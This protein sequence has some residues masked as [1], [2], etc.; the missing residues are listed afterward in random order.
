MKELLKCTCTVRWNIRQCI[1]K[2]YSCKQFL[3]L[4]NK[5]CSPEGSV[6]LMK[7]EAADYLQSDLD[8]EWFV[9]VLTFGPLDSNNKLESH[10]SNEVLFFEYVY[11]FI[12]IFIYICFAEAVKIFHL[13]I[14][15]LLFQFTFK[16]QAF[17]SKLLSRFRHFLPRYFQDQ[18]FSS[19]LLP[20]W[21]IFFQVTS[22]IRHFL[23]SYFQDQIFSCK[24]LQDQTFSCK[25]LQDQT[26]SSKIFQDTCKNNAL[27]SKILEVKSD[28]FLQE[29]Y[30]S[31]TGDRTEYSLAKL[32]L[33]LFNVIDYTIIPHE[34]S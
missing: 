19:K 32:S 14:F 11:I 33:L 8:D 18:A 15:R 27:S 24:I 21:G 9:E 2:M 16:I 4:L 20:R 31:S 3:L 6:I 5:R 13:E 23:P 1:Q 22:K 28:R 10:M 7:T 26:L 34:D 30:G 17:S 29:M 25:I 12:F